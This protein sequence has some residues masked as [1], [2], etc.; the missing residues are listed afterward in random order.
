M[1]TKNSLCKQNFTTIDLFS[2]SGGMSE[3]FRRAGFKVVCA[4]DTDK[5]V[6]ETYTT[7][8]KDAVFIC[9]KIE[10]V[11]SEKIFDTVFNKGYE[12]IDLIIGG[13]PC[14]G[15]SMANMRSRTA[16]NPKNSLPHHFIRLVKDIKP[17]YFVMENVLGL[18]TLAKGEIKDMFIK[19]FIKIGYK[20]E[21]RVLNSVY[22][23]V[24]QKRERVFF[25]G[26][27]EN[28]FP[29]VFP[30]YT[31]L[32]PG[33]TSFSNARTFVTMWDAISDLPKIGDGGGGNNVDVYHS[34]PKNDYQV[35][36]RERKSAPNSKLFNH[37]S[38]RS[39][40]NVIERFRHIPSGGNWADIPEKLLKINGEYKRLDRTHSHI[41]KKL[42][43]DKPAPTIA[44]FRKA[45]LQHPYENR[46][47]S[48]REAARLQSFPDNY[49]FQG[50]ISAMQQQVADAVPVLLAEAVAKTLADLLLNINDKG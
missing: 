48:V 34:K 2:G 28:T 13:P 4:L 6:A 47:L 15:F 9:E 32:S 43:P 11:Q 1:A 37:I 20:V 42:C 3:G 41:Y 19:E 33:Q 30:T 18:L 27:K 24:P 12:D 26:C 29:I 35:I 22:Y 50:G 8:H 21:Y 38:T 46:I 10:N 31:H 36:M 44:N 23:G 5:A 45:M 17:K 7:N 40:E 14:Q 39:S 16:D 25:I 49:I